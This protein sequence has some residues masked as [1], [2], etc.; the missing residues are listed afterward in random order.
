MHIFAA[1]P[2][3]ANDNGPGSELESLI[4][5]IKTCLK[6]STAT[7][8][9]HSF[10]CCLQITFMDVLWEAIRLADG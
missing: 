5:A 8:V 7:P 9:I 4:V 10:S 3:T 2:Y 6:R 1:V